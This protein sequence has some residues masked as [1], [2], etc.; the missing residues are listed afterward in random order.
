M[1]F[2]GVDNEEERDKA[3]PLEVVA[4]PFIDSSLDVQLFVP[5][6][7]CSDEFIFIRVFLFVHYSLNSLLVY[8]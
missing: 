5:H 2:D 8:L 3:F 1:I 7:P 4:D 6:A